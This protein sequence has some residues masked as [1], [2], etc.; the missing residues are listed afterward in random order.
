MFGRAAEEEECGLL[1]QMLRTVDRQLGAV[2]RQITNINRRIAS[3]DTIATG[4]LT[5]LADHWTNSTV[6]EEVEE[7]GTMVEVNQT[8]VY[9]TR[10]D[11]GGFSFVHTVSKTKGDEVGVESVKED[12]G[13]E[14]LESK[15]AEP[16]QGNMDG[17]VVEVTQKG[18]GGE[19]DIAIQN[20][21][22]NVRAVSDEEQS[23][24]DEK[25]DLKQREEE[26]KLKHD[27]GDVDQEQE[28]EIANC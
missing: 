2:Q 8:T 24:E 16:V 9:E 1:C 7:D 3:W 25:G 6:V 13:G 15:L 10:K 22:H 20:D 19:D 28:N 18:F 26:E 12:S 5:H 21:N 17:S 27:D 14:H 23:E 11:G 4:G